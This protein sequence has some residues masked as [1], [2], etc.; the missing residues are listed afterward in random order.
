[1]VNEHLIVEINE[2]FNFKKVSC[3]EGH[4]IT[5]WNKDDILDFTSSTVM[6]CPM[7]VDLSVYYCISEEEYNELMEK[8]M[9]AMKEKEEERNKIENKEE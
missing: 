7:S 3:K 2:K 9:I 6:Y 5:D 1:M 8:Q 4:Y